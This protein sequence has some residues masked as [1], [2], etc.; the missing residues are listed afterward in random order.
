MSAAAGDHLIND[1]YT[2]IR[3]IGRGSTGRVYVAWDGH[4]DR[5]VAIK[6]LDQSYLE[7]KEVRGRFEREIHC[8]ARLQHPGLVAVF[9]SGM[10]PDGSLCYIMSL[11]RGQTLD[12]YLDQL[13]KSDDHWRT[14]SL[15]DRLTL[16][17]K[18]LEVINYAHSQDVVHRDLKPANIMIG[19]F[20]EVWILDWGLARNLKDSIIADAPPESEIAYEDLFGGF[21]KRSSATVI[22]NGAEGQEKT[23]PVANDPAATV[24]SGEPAVDAGS[25]RLA[26]S[27]MVPLSG[28]DALVANEIEFKPSSQRYPVGSNSGGRVPTTGRPTSSGARGKSTSVQGTA[29]VGTAKT[30]KAE[31][32]THFGDVLGSPSYMSPEQAGGHASAADKRSDIYSL[33]VILFELLTLRTPVEM[34]SDEKLTQ[35]IKRV[36]LGERRSLQDIW[37]DAPRPLHEMCESALALDP[38]KRFID[39]DLFAERLRTLLAQLSASYSEMERQ[40]LATEREGAWN[41]VGSWDFAATPGLGPFV[42]APVARRSETVGQ[43]MHP[44]LGGLL[45]GGWGLQMY[46]LS[47]SVSDD[48][49]LILDLDVIHGSECWIFVRGVPPASC[50]QFRIGA[51]MGRWLAIGRSTGEDDLLAPELLTMQPLRQRSAAMADPSQQIALRGCRL[52]IEA[53]GSQLSLSIDDQPPLVVQD[54]CP[55]SGPLNRQLAVGTFESHAVIRR[56]SVQQRRSPLMLPSFA[57]GNE[58]LRQR[59]YAQAIDSYRRFLFEHPD[60]NEAAEANFMLCLAYIRAGQSSQAEREL[61]NF[62][63]QY[64]DHPLSQDAIFEL[65]RLIM[66]Q[67]GSIER[68]V[69]VVL[70]YQETGDFVRSRFCM[71]LMSRLS[72]R[73][74]IGGMT[75]DI[76]AD[77]E[78]IRQLIRGSPDED[79]IIATLSADLAWKA[80]EYINDLHDQGEYEAIQDARNIIAQAEEI[81]FT[82]LLHNKYTQ[83]EYQAIAEHLRSVDDPAQTGEYLRLGITDPILVGHFI[84]DVLSL[85]IEGC[86]EHVIAIL[87]GEQLTPVE[88]VLRACLLARRKRIDEL[89]ADLMRCFQLTDVLEV[90]RSDP[91]L[92]IAARLGCYGLGFLPWAQ[93]WD[94]SS[95]SARDQTLVPLEVLAGF[96]AESLG[97]NQDAAQAYRFALTPG[98]GFASI[99]RH[100]LQKMG[101][102]TN[103]GSFAVLV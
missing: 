83:P 96:L 35:L 81:G 90:E 61:R 98:T 100:G 78:M 28:E 13:R 26:A 91:T 102:L 60:C 25:V 38:Q 40:R 70:S 46:P 18:I 75:Q 87:Q 72:E 32:A 85:A 65:A 51:F 7:D 5:E 66:E 22:L 64:I 1:R 6:V 99:A 68:S 37:A 79:L 56:V 74:R 19:S 4:L 12:Q 53:I 59:M 15:L 50:Y 41:T 54:T 89:N 20:G 44:E 80:R 82:F 3:E 67:S 57:V 88:L 17:L 93:V 55:L 8:T 23:E 31:R 97:R 84:R 77:L 42:E 94:S 62:L 34:R 92:L 58:L 21:E 36:Q 49:R 69:R 103:S 73:I 2:L 27:P 14:A 52:V 10:L 33:G 30:G 63:S 95:R 29:S 101:L 9:E 16:F 11:A 43:V 24:L 76:V 39:C 48:M 47:V 86:E 45:V 71:L